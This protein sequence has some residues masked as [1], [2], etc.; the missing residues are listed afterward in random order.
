MAYDGALPQPPLRFSNVVL[1]EMVI[2][3]VL[4]IV[5]REVWI[6][7]A[8]AC[9]SNMVRCLERVEGS[10]TLIEP[11][12]AVPTNSV[13]VYASRGIGRGNPTAHSEED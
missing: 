5:E 8:A 2:K 4:R 3:F 1:V 12:G 9:V 7:D 11:G 13:G 6:I 10:T